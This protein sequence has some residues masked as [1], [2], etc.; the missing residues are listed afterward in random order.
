MPDARPTRFDLG[1]EG[2][3]HLDLLPW[4]I[5]DEAIV[6]Q[7]IDPVASEVAALQVPVS[8]DDLSGVFDKE[9]PE[10]AAIWCDAL[11]FKRSHVL[12]MQH[13]LW[14]DLD[15]LIDVGVGPGSRTGLPLEC[16]E[17]LQVRITELLRSP[18]KS[19]LPVSNL[20]GYS[21]CHLLCPGRPSDRGRVTGTDR[22]S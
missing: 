9:A 17:A 19:R 8:A 11:R 6:Q 10:A 7:S 2:L 12:V 18:L 21:S 22:N 15:Q 14:R 20:S 4:N 5:G 16:A 1:E 3:E 13:A